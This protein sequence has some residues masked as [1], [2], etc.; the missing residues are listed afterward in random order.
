MS[1]RIELWNHH[2]ITLI[3]LKDGKE[4]RPA[5]IMWGP[6]ATHELDQMTA[7]NFRRWLDVAQR[8]HNAV[9]QRNEGQAP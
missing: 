7:D 8:T 5:A 1:L 4:G 6:N 9:A 3:A 2:G